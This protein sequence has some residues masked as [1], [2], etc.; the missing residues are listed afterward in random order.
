[1]LQ[2]WF[3]SY[4]DG[5]HCMDGYAAATVAHSRLGLSARYVPCVYGQDAPSVEARDSVWILDFSYPRVVLENLARCVQSL[6]V[7]DHHK[8]AQE[9]LAGLS[10]AQFDME[11]SG[12]QMAWDHFYRRHRRPALVEYVADRDLWRHA[13]PDTQL[14]SRALDSLPRNFE[15]WEPLLMM[16]EYARFMA[17]IGAPLYEKHLDAVESAVASCALYTDRDNNLVAVAWLEDQSLASD[18]LNR[19]CQRFGASYAVSVTDVGGQCKMSLRS[20]GDFDVSA[21]AR[22]WGGGGHKNAAGCTAPDLEVFLLG[23]HG[24]VQP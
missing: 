8:T 3:H 18:A 13:L 22:R 4:E 11:R 20:I 2:V 21:I 1:M 16:P 7:L 12:A 15:V 17:A 23:A 6:V 5:R 14:V 24:A 10:F 9:D 19:A